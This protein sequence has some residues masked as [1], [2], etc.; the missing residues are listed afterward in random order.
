MIYCFAVIKLNS[1]DNIQ[2]DIY[3]MESKMREKNLFVLFTCELHSEYGFVRKFF[4]KKD[5][6]LRFTN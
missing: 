4:L 2:L 3:H 5:M 6:L 1:R